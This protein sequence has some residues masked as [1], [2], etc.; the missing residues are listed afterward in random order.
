MTETVCLSGAALNSETS[1]NLWRCPVCGQDGASRPYCYGVCLCHEKSL[2]RYPIFVCCLQLCLTR[3]NSAYGS[4]SQ[5]AC[6]HSNQQTTMR[7][8]RLKQPVICPRNLCMSVISR[9]SHGGLI[10]AT[11]TA[12]LSESVGSGVVEARTAAEI[13]RH[14]AAH[15]P[16]A[17]LRYLQHQLAR[18]FK[19]M[20]MWEPVA[21]AS[22][23]IMIRK[24]LSVARLL[25]IQY[26][27]YAH[28]S[29]G[30]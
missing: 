21:P 10:T 3:G 12:L 19:L 7:V 2:I 9:T 20:A 6:S 16:S 14:P 28:E 17:H 13:R 15:L 22:L 11:F 5:P 1:L 8:G 23:R 27:Y 18:S 29:E 25:Q 26:L 30:A 4:V 24:N